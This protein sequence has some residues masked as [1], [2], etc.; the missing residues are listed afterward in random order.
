MPS[1]IAHSGVALI[2]WPVLTTPARSDV[3]RRD[4]YVMSGMLV[5]MVC[6]A[7]ADF[8]PHLLLDTSTAVWRH[9][10]ATH[11]LL[12]GAAV[13]VVFAL[14]MRALTCVSW[15]RLW[16]VG[17]LAW[18]SH[19]ALDYVTPG[20]GVMA[21]W[22]ISDTRFVSPISLFWGA[23]HSQPLAFHLHAIT[24]LTEL[25]FVLLMWWAGRRIAR[26]QRQFDAR[27][28]VGR[29]RSEPASP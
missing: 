14:A 15:W 4:H 19:L 13:A 1:P 24:L 28:V 16:M 5:F 12:A 29:L 26:W 7:D 22:P 3:S 21:F 20:G 10:G 8:I 23:E 17:C 25:P 9:G 18:W 2:L 27:N 6:G 11:S